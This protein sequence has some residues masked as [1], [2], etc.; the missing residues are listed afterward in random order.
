MIQFIYHLPKNR[1]NR[2]LIPPSRSH[3]MNSHFMKLTKAAPSQNALFPTICHPSVPWRRF[4]WT[5]PGHSLCRQRSFRSQLLLRGSP[6]TSTTP[7][8]VTVNLLGTRRPLLSPV[9]PVHTL[10]SLLK[11]NPR[12]TARLH[13]VL[14]SHILAAA[15]ISTRFLQTMLVIAQAAHFTSLVF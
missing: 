15:R 4:S 6:L 8:S 5:R 1:K 12:H 11:K 13:P 9:P 3:L 14:D 7:P 10:C 2:P